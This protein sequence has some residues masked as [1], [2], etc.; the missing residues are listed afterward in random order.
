MPYCPSCG[1]ITQWV[2]PPL[3]K[4]TKRSRCVITAW[5]WGQYVFYTLFPFTTTVALFST[6]DAVPLLQQPSEPNSVNLN[7]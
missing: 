1:E 4:A 3:S 5:C 6:L 7:A 2:R